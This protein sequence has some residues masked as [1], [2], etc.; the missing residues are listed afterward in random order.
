MRVTSGSS[1]SHDLDEPT[2][3]NVHM[4]MNVILINLI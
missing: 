3:E 1:V 4:R 2:Q